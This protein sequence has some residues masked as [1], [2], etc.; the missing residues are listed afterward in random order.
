MT[1]NAENLRFI[2]GLKLKRLRL[3]K[4]YSLKTLS[5]RSGLSISYISEIEKGK[6]YPKPQ[7]ILGLASALEVSFDELV[8]LKVDEELSPLKSIFNSAF[9]Q[10][11]P[12]E[13]FGLALEDLFGII[14]NEPEKAGA[15][16]RTFLEIGHMYDVRV[17]H[18]LFAALRSYQQMHANYFEDLEGVAAT[19]GQ[20]RGLSADAPIDEA[21][22][23]AVLVDEYGYV[24]DEDTLP[25]HPVLRRFRSVFLDG[26]RR[27]LLV[28]G[29]M[30]PAQKAFI[31]AREIGYRFLDLK[32]RAL[33]SSWLKVES[34]DQVFNNFKASYFAGALLIDQEALFREM[35]AFF[36][37][38]TWDERALLD[39]MN[40]FNATP[41]MFFYRLTELLPRLFGLQDIFFVRFNHTPGDD[42][43]RLTK[44]LNMSRVAVPHGIWLNEHYCRRWPDM[45]LLERLA[46]RQ[47]EGLGD[48]PVAAAQRSHFMDADA[49]Y[50]VISIARPLAL[51][52]GK[53]SCV[54]L[55]FL[56]NAPFK[57]TV[58]FWKDPSIPNAEVNLTCQRCGFLDCPDRAAEPA[59]F[60]DQKEHEEQDRA[61]QELIR[62]MRRA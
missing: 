26:N 61:L 12:F 1:M 55:G 34:F 43:F 20:T 19:Y 54:S 36:A 28:N 11:F 29:R 3:D 52:P 51:Q 39:I 45:P 48:G 60:L 31:F 10:E 6:K 2:L 4:G 46:E 58:K 62:K 38:K 7:K 42:R 8:S 32:P 21:A 25:T 23:R 9:I 22:L 30:L 13:L 17:E 14:K 56:V 5:E 50:F 37:R 53:N 47:R 35:K 24:I 40:R 18:F 49:D 57:K 41:E 44:V 15:L 27:R 59:I 16:I 33:T